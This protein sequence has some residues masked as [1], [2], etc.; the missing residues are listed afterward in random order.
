LKLLAIETSSEGCSAALFLDGKVVEDYRLAPRQHGKLILQMIE[1]ILKEANLKLTELD[2]LAFGRGPGSFAGL[3][4]AAGVIQGLAFGAE[5]PVVPVSTLAAISLQAQDEF[6]GEQFFSAFDARLDEVYWGVY[7][8]DDAALVKPIVNEQVCSADQVVVPI[9]I[10]GVAVGSG[11]ES[12]RELLEKRVGKEAIIKRVPDCIPKAAS[13]ARLAAIAFE[14]GQAITAEQAQP[15]YLRDKVAK[16]K[17]EQLAEKR[18][19]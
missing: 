15:I 1:S 9:G 12:H 13:I 18:E 7:Q 19:R 11:W 16:T 3:R 10:K 17:V 6:G 2:G 14:N 4:I 5:L 8:T